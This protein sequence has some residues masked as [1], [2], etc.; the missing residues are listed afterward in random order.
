MAL[1]LKCGALAR[2]A[3]AVHYHP[4]FANVLGHGLET[5]E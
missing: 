1:E 3:G 2:C 4:A 5:G